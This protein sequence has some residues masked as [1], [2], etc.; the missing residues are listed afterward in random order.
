MKVQL[1]F[2]IFYQRL[3][4][5]NMKLAVTKFWLVDLRIRLKNIFYWFRNLD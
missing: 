5:P 3:K 1:W 4:I 2:T